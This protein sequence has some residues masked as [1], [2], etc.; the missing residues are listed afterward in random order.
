M[1]EELYY[2]GA[3]VGTVAPVDL[4][5]YGV[6]FKCPSSCP[7]TEGGVEFNKFTLGVPTGCPCATTPLTVGLSDG[8]A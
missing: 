1:V 7:A 3:C 8:V 5:K 4:V 2:L 6:C